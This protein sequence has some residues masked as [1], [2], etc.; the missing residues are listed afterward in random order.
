M[1]AEAVI[2]ARG[3]SKAFDGFMAVEDVALEIRAGEIF[4]FL[5]PNGAGKTTTIRMLLGLLLPTRGASSVLGFDSQRQSE[6]IRQRV[7]YVSQHFSL[8]PDLTVRENLDFYGRTYGLARE[9]LA[10]RRRHVLRATGLEGQEA[11]LTRELAGGFRQRLALATA[12]L[13]DP[14]VLILDE[15]TAGVDPITR[16]GFWD[17]LYDLAEDG[18]TILITTH[19]MD[20]AE[21]CHRLAFI[22]DGRVV[23]EGSPAGI[24][25][26]M[27][28]DVLELVSRPPEEAVTVLR[29]RLAELG[30]EEAALYG[31]ALHLVG[32][33]LEGRRG[34][35]ERALVAAG[36]RVESLAPIP[37]SLEDVFVAR[38]RPLQGGGAA[39][40]A[41]SEER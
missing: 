37:P 9:R 23:L 21:G 30:L 12:V 32:P 25:Q 20:E 17:F 18:K 31:N 34:E 16:R 26:S 2:Q 4:G 19:Y 8:Y 11:R 29:R 24:R 27:E 35:I 36:V 13:H 7:G 10:E 15:P 33:G 3:L 5:G 39:E 41:K 40:P 14:P 22:H 6:A 28:G 1:T 38:I